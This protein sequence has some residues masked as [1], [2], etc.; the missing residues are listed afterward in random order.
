M[1]WFNGMFMVQAK[2]RSAVVVMGEGCCE[3]RWIVSVKLCEAVHNM[4]DVD[5]VCE[6]FGW[7][8]HNDVVNDS[9]SDRFCCLSWLKHKPDKGLS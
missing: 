7:V 3:W 8:L 1:S 9:L 2:K 6:G 5:N 4:K